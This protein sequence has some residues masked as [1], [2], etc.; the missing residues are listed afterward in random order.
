MLTFRPVERAD[1][2][3]LTDMLYEALYVAPGQPAYPRE[4]LESPEI[5]RYLTDYGRSGDVGLIAVV[6]GEPVGAAWSRL[7]QTGNHGYG[8][9][10]EET[11][12][13]T[14][15]VRDA[16]RGRDIGTM[17]LEELLT[18][19]DSEYESTA[20]SVHP[21]SQAVRLYK[22][23]GYSHVD[24]VGESMLMVRFRSEISAIAL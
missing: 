3:F 16:F 24:W 19:L 5:A 11:P 20:L 14:I 17:L 13:I 7:W 12:E 6:A 8:F 15:A 21:R 22:R 9:V 2:P 4:I 23:L 18:R 10:D 1:I